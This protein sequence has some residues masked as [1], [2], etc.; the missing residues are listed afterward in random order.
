M[1][2]ISYEAS[3]LFRNNDSTMMGTWRIRHVLESASWWCWRLHWGG[4]Q[5]SH[6][7]IP[8]NRHDIK[9]SNYKLVSKNLEL[10]C[11]WAWQRAQQRGQRRLWLQW[12]HQRRRLQPCLVRSSGRLRCLVSALS[13]RRLVFLLS[14]RLAWLDARLD[15]RLDGWLE[16]WLE[17]WLALEVCFACKRNPSGRCSRRRSTRQSCSKPPHSPRRLRPGKKEM[18]NSNLLLAIL[19]I[20]SQLSLRC[21]LVPH[22]AKTRGQREF[23]PPKKT[24]HLRPL[25]N[26]PRSLRHCPSFAAVQMVILGWP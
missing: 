7:P 15:A 20:S 16:G 11:F 17:H 5:S 8:D 3:T 24:L 18:I 9:H 2:R 21:C 14:S 6:F 19:Y 12:Q 1:E 26:Q 25:P 13:G 4:K 22:P 23:H 10:T